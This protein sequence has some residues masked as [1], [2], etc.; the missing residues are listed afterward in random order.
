LS[1]LPTETP[2]RRDRTY[3]PEELVIEAIDEEALREARERSVARV[4]LLWKKSGLLMRASVYGLMLATAIAFLIPKRYESTAELMPPDQSSSSGTAMLAALSSQVGGGLASMAES[5]LGMKTTG[6]LFVGI[7]DSDTVRDDVIHKFNLQK[8]YGTRYIEDARKKLAEHTAISEDH[9]SGIISISVVDHDPHRA[10]AMAQEYVNKLN[11][12]VT[13]LSTSAAHRERVFLDQRLKQVNANLD[14]AE[15]EFSQFASKNGAIDVPAQGKAM[16]TAAAALQGQLIAAESELQGLR[17]IYT[18]DNMRVRS[19]QARVNEL[20]KS[21]ADIAGKGANENSSAGQLFPSIGQ[22]PLLGVTYANLLRRTKVEEAVFETLTQQDE[23]AKVQ[24]AKE[25]PS[26][27]VL[28]PPM[29]PQKKS[30][31][32]RMLIIVLGTLLSLILCASWILA[33]SAWAAVD[34]RE[35]RKA[36]AIEVWKDLRAGLPWTAKNGSPPGPEAG[37]LRRKLFR[38]GKARPSE[39]SQEATTPEEK[40]R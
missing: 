23:L 31:P 3:I 14:E 18:D 16:V 30:F 29:V 9:A 38:D 28:D 7:L 40:R 24:E 25:I 8:V 39:R 5:A 6:A 19:V 27:K 4:R 11:W 22:L 15:K 33:S 10:E 1:D 34:P 17:Q 20:R 36:V 12:V 35:P 13:H 32:P 2:T 21:L 37:W 26:V